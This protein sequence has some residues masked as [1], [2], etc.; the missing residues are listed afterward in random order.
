MKNTKAIK[1]FLKIKVNFEKVKRKS[2]GKRGEKN[3]N[4]KIN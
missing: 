3:T 4:F 1:I 2:I